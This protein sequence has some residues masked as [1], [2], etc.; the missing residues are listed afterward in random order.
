M[1]VFLSFLPLLLN[2]VIILYEY[3]RRSISLFL[4]ATLL[5]MF[6]VFHFVSVLSSFLEYPIWVYNEASLFVFIFNLLYLSTRVITKNKGFCETY[7][8]KKL[9]ISH[10]PKA[11]RNMYH[12]L[13]ML[14]LMSII[15]VLYNS[16]KATGSIFS[17]SWGA[18]L[19][20]SREQDY[21]NASR[22]LSP[23][24]FPSAALLFICRFFKPWKK[25]LP[26]VVVLLLFNVLITRNRIQI[27][28][29][30][31]FGIVLYMANYKLTIK[32]M[33]VYLFVGIIV[34]YIIYALQIYR[35]YGTI[36]NFLENTSWG[37]FNDE[38]LAK[39]LSNEG[40]LGLRNIFYYFISKSNNFD[41]FGEGHTYLR[42]LLFW[43]PTS[44][45]GGIKPDD[46]A[47]AMG[48]AWAPSSWGYSVHPTLYGDCYANFGMYGAFM[49]VFWAIFVNISD[50]I[51][52]KSSTILQYICV[53]SFACFYV[54]IGRGSVYNAFIWLVSSLFILYFINHFI[55]KKKI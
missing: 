49:G 23:F 26:I 32:N 48:K 52:L 38:I 47:I 44:W 15:M 31:C 36:D 19:I 53:M 41:G 5:V 3:K 12:L 25:Y 35:Y 14:L 27:L 37:K 51:T 29:I 22:L 24:F 2:I 43:L 50:Y 39:I 1:A 11:G 18:L 40:D 21:V 6:S 10:V 13:W 8:K 17:S 16:Y 46:F 54:I 55:F 33:L 28:P 7:Y 4:W 45:S 34:I 30:L 9:L 42:M 20:Y